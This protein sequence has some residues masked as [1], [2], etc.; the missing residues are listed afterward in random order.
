MRWLNL[1]MSYANSLTLSVPWPP[2]SR[3]SWG[4]PGKQNVNQILLWHQTDFCNTAGI[5]TFLW[6]IP[7]AMTTLP[8]VSLNGY[9][10]QHIRLGTAENTNKW[11]RAAQR[12]FA[13]N[14]GKY[15]I[16]YTSLC[17]DR[18][19]VWVTTYTLGS[20]G[21][22]KQI[23]QSWSYLPLVSWEL[24]KPWTAIL[25]TSIDYTSVS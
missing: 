11:P 2:V 3:A 13:K 21:L 6:S 8:H 1:S 9:S 16:R 17:Y 12:I 23:S 22:I 18:D 10:T 5:G 7:I 20:N 14:F 4:L 19:H 15:D 24:V 25:A